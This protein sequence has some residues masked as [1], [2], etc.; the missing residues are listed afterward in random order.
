MKINW[1]IDYENSKASCELMDV[2]I[3]EIKNDDK[4]IQEINGIKIGIGFQKIESG[5]L[6]FC[7]IIKISDILFEQ[8]LK[9]NKL[10]P[11]FASQLGD[12]F[13]ESRYTKKA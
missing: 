2:E 9:D 10:L 1:I 4:P 7:K 11:N 3:I 8:N 13:D 6:Y 5:K 12:L